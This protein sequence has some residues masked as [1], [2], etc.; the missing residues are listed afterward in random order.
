MGTDKEEFS[1][2]GELLFVFGWLEPAE[3]ADPA[4]W[5]DFFCMGLAKVISM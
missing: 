1:L 5:R 4:G 3:A 2:S